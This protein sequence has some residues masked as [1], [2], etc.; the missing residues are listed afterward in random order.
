MGQ[1]Q[2]LSSHTKFRA[3]REFITWFKKAWPIK[4]A[5]FRSTYVNLSEM[6]LGRFSISRPADPGLSIP[7][8]CRLFTVAHLVSSTL[9]P[10]SSPPARCQI[11]CPGPPKL[12]RSHVEDTRDA[13]WW[14]LDFE[15]TVG[16]TSSWSDW[17][18]GWWPVLGLSWKKSPLSWMDSNW[19]WDPFS[20]WLVSGPLK[21]NC[22]NATRS[23]WRA[24]F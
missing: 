21:V 24:R 18:L 13:G 19:G 15:P 14:K 3:A 1:N 23:S 11:F 7:A 9:M 10:R 4:K 17:S 20:W 22:W 5:V 16:C 12:S 8:L 2:P 6:K